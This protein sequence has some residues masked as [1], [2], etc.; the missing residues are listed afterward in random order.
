[1][2]AK[3][4][5]GTKAPAQDSSCSDKNCP[6][7][8]SV[9]VRGREFVGTVISDKMSKTV[10]V[11]WS[12]RA[13]VK[14]YERYERKWSKINAHNPDCINAKK[15]DVVKVQET[16]PLSKTKHFAIIQVIGRESKKEYVKAESIED[17]DV[18]DDAPKKHDEKQEKTE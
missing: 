4:T 2:V 10:V 14:K 3:K 6:A 13:F 15:G 12:R 7:H 11:S 16:R 5:E 8:G 9:K 18:R 17:E 1:M